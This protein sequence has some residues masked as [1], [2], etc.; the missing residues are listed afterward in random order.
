LFVLFLDENQQQQQPCD[1]GI[2][3][4]NSDHGGGNGNEN[5]DPGEGGGGSSDLPQAPSSG[6]SGS[7]SSG[8]NGDDDDPN[9]RRPTYD[10]QESTEVESKEEESNEDDDGLQSSSHKGQMVT[11]PLQSALRS[12]VQ[13]TSDT[14]RQHQGSSIVPD[15]EMCSNLQGSSL[16]ASVKSFAHS[17]QLSMC[18]LNEK[19]VVHESPID[20]QPQQPP[21][22]AASIEEEQLSLELS[23]GA[24]T[25]EE[26][27][28]DEV[29]HTN[30]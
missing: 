18:P 11:N 8:D 5:S 2:G 19:I 29:K 15:H 4:Q 1:G 12:H 6:G 17:E 16:Y 23:S 28:L 7:S 25:S 20:E 3:S 22:S 27:I 21:Q 9:K 26:G 14:N 10:I 24:S 13:W 30:A